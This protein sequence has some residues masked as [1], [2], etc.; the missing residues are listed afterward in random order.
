MKKLL[1]FALKKH[2]APQVLAESYYA[3]SILAKKTIKK[4]I[5]FEYTVRPPHTL[6]RY[7][8]RENSFY[9]RHNRR[10]GKT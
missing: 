4:Y 10:L 1:L 5:T 9:P 7:I 3:Q 6:T 2:Q 8:G